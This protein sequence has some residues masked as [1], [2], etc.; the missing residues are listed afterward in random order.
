MA[1][2][3]MSRSDALLLAAYLVAMAEPFTEE[4]FADVLREVHDT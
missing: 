4:K 1:V 2:A 3:R